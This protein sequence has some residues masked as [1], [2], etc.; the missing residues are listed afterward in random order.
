MGKLIVIE[1]TD[2]SG[3]STQF[4]LLSERMEREGVA[5]K[6][7]VFPRYSEESSAL[8]RMYLGGQFGKNP[9]DV[10]AYAASS[11]YAVDRY[12]SYKMDWGQWYEQGGVVLS[13]RYT[14]S[15][16]V[17]QTSKEPKDKQPEFLGWL[18]DF[19]YE[20]LGLPRPDL[21][22]YL[23]VPTDFTEKLLR[24]REQDTNTKADI[25]EKDTAYLATCRE[26]GR[27]AAAYYGW[28]VVQCV[29]DGQMRTIE[30]IHEEIY[31]HVK[32]CL[33]E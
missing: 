7:I 24:H 32:K 15:N 30:D 12:A 22:L 20:K 29:K 14:T 11:F 3:K 27:A 18:Y 33:E 16:A 10:N 2:G 26:T 13:D 5:F 17:H 9:S 6:H 28:T 25:H 23:D 1:G 8:I 31:Q 19:E 4:R 21:T